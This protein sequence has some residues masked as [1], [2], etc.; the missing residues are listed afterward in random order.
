MV[1]LQ[2][3][4]RHITLPDVGVEGQAKLCNARVL[5]IGAGGLGSPT[6]LYLAAAG[7]GTIGIVDDDVVEITNLQRQVIHDTES[8]GTPKVTSAQTR[9]QALDP[10]VNIIPFTTRLNPDNVGEIFS[11]GWDLIIDGT[12]NIPTRYLID[13][14]AFILEIPW[15]YGS[16]YR[17]EGQ[18]SVFNFEGGPCYRDL[19]HTPPPSEAIP[20][21][22]EG[23]VI[24][25]LPAVVGS[26]QATEA[27]KM[28]IGIGEVLSGKL[29]V[30]DALAMSFD[31]LKFSNDPNR[32]EVT[33]LDSAAA[34][35][36]ESE[37][38]SLTNV[39]MSA[40][41]DEVQKGGPL[42]VDT[43]FH[44]LSM[45]EYISRRD[46]GWQPF[47][48]DVRSDMEHDQARIASCNF[49]IAHDSVTSALD[50]IPRDQD[51]VIHCRSGMRSQ[52]AAMFLMQNGYDADK[53]YNLEGG[54]MA[55][56]SALPGEIVN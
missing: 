48:L 46:S 28:I 17:F 4:Q 54:I 16:I 2:R 15:V 19:F 52:M 8:L 38:C 32:P 11:Q 44:Q 26:I 13:D 20:S 47:I 5:V 3:H 41:N 23:G 35:F 56:Q 9:L 25:V 42:A 1:D 36:D 27:V 18:V 10:A 21:C 50:Q 33:S 51:L 43:M 29:L 39:D 14:A 7:V 31:T 55:W 49:Q 34:L 45:A 30:Y 12:D 37:F 24:G 22:A 40:R 6:L 53:L